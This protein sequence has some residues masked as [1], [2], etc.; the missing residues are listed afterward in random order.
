MLL[1]LPRPPAPSFGHNFDSNSS[2]I[3]TPTSATVVVILL[4]WV[5]KSQVFQRGQDERTAQME[6]PEETEKKCNHF[7]IQRR[8]IVS[9]PGGSLITVDRLYQRSLQGWCNSFGAPWFIPKPLV[10]PGKAETGVGLVIM[11][12]VPFAV[13]EGIVDFAQKVRHT[14]DGQEEVVEKSNVYRVLNPGWLTI[15]LAYH[16][17]RMSIIRLD[18]AEGGQSAGPGTAESQPAREDGC[19]LEWRVWWKPL[20]VPL[21]QDQWERLIEKM[22]QTIIT[23]ICDYMAAALDDE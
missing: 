11:R 2:S 5:V 4:G 13:R 19:L 6:T 9:R 17:G 1:F 16:V 14:K 15:P 3:L 18:M 7:F 20:P 22:I 12:L 23:M 21:Y 8:R 10:K